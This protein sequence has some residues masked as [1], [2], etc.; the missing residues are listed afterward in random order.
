MAVTLPNIEGQQLRVAVLQRDDLHEAFVEAQDDA[1]SLWV[2]DGLHT[3]LA[4]F[5]CG[6]GRGGGGERM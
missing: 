1:A 2:Y 5:T 3:G 4:V 6:E